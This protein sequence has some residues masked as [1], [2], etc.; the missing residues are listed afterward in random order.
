M[1]SIGLATE[2]HSSGRRLRLRMAGQ[3]PAV[4]EDGRERSL[5]TP[6]DLSRGFIFNH[7]VPEQPRDQPAKLRFAG[8]SPAVVSTLGP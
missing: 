1:P 8:A 2:G 5:L 6:S 3:S 4:T 7:D